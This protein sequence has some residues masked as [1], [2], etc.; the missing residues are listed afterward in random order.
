M[1]YRFIKLAI[2]WAAL[3]MGCLSSYGRMYEPLSEDPYT[4][5]QAKEWKQEK[6]TSSNSNDISDEDGIGNDDGSGPIA[7]NLT[8]LVVLL[9]G[10]GWIR[11]R[12]QKKNPSTVN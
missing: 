2:L 10:Y 7:D 5:Y 12:K 1:K 11:Y 3:T 6:S 8:Y 4:R 9:L